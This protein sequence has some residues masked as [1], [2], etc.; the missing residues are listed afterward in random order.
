MTGK[1]SYTATFASSMLRF[2]VLFLSYLLMPLIFC[3]LII[4]RNE[5]AGD[6]MEIFL[7]GIIGLVMYFIA[8]AMTL[9]AHIFEF[10]RCSFSIEFSDSL[11]IARDIRGRVKELNWSEIMKIRPSKK[12]L[13]SWEPIHLIIETKEG[14]EIILHHNIGPLGE[15]VHEIEQRSPNLKSIDYGGLDRTRYWTETSKL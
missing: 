10:Q 9:P 2:W 11:V 12:F 1:T 8:I 7:T 3:G 6:A 15:C 13:L 4:F 5:I 14:K